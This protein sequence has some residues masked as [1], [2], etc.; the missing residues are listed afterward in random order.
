MKNELLLKLGQKIRFER[1]KKN[2]SQDDLADL[3]GLSKQAISAL[4]T[5]TSNVKFLNL[6][7]IANALDLDLGDFKDF[8]L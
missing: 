3:V 6:H 5:G 4:E 7:N 2:L 8:R 1:L